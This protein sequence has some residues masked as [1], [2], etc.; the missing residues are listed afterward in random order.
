VTELPQTA[1]DVAAHRF[2]QHSRYAATEVVTTE[3][4]QGGE[5][6]A[7]RRRFIAQTD[8]QPPLARHLVKAGDRL[9]LLAELYYGDPLLAWRIADANRAFDP[10]Q[11]T[12]VPGRVLAIP[13]PDAT[14]AF[15]SGADA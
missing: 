2:P 4:P 9:D 6:R 11:L 15:T 14:T 8:T 12:A 10:A 1:G 5:V 3:G 7:L 13:A